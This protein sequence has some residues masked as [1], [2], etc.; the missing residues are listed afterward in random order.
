MRAHT[1]GF[2]SAGRIGSVD[3]LTKSLREEFPELDPE[4]LRAAVERAVARA[5]NAAMD[6]EGYRVVDLHLAQVEATEESTERAQILRDLSDN[7]AE[8]GDADRALVTRLA[9][10]GE[11]PNASDIEPL[12][13][14]G[15]MTQRWSELPLDAMS[16][17]ID[18]QDDAAPGQLTELANA[19]QAVGRAYYAADCLERVLLVAPNDK[20][21]NEALEV[22]Y[23][24]TNEWPSLVELLNR[25]TVH[26]DTDRERAGI[27]RE[28]GRIYEKELGDEPGA[29]DAYR[30]ADR[31]QPDHPD[32][33]DA[34]ARLV[35]RV[36]DSEG[37]AL[38]KVEKL[39][40]ALTEPKARAAAWCRAAELAKLENWDKAATLF[41][42]ARARTIPI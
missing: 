35:V 34:L 8:R 38:A 11:A 28:I 6:T 14:L 2:G 9:A 24:S 13:R 32:A 15:R 42:R 33:L 17:L 41:Q 18:L 27:F 23:R 21:A 5:A 4:R 1:G 20:R 39:A 7:L 30:E 26:V 31:L 12:L 40:A 29:L 37:E 10:F 3:I 25:R 19:W 16:G 36:G 22:F